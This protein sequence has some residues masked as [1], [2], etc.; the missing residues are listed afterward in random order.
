MTLNPVNDRRQCDAIVNQR[1][2]RSLNHRGLFRWS[3][4]R[5]RLRIETVDVNA[6]ELCKSIADS[7][8]NAYIFNRRCSFTPPETM[9]MGTTTRLSLKAMPIVLDVELVS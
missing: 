9:I 3:C 4:P 6:L 7:F 5:T 2:T 1:E 8:T